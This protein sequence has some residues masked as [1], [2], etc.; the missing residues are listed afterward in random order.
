VKAIIL[1][2]GVGN[3]LKPVTDTMPKCLIEIGGKTILERMLD[4]LIDSGVEDISLVVGYKKRMIVDFAG[5]KYRGRAFDFIDNP[6]YELGSIVSLLVAREKFFGSDALLMDA[7]VIFERAVLEKLIGSKNANCFV[8][9]RDFGLWGLKDTGEEMK[10]AAL[11]KKVVQIARKI[12]REHDEA[13][14]GVG[15]C[16]I[17]AAYYGEF[18]KALENR[19]CLNRNCDYELALD[20]FIT[21]A[22]AGFE[23]ITGMKW[24]EIDFQED[25][26]KAGS[27][28]L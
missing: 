27:L 8:I 21:N 17:S 20:D 12:T 14:E 3:R 6:D 26:G 11:D 23:E 4:S 1:A 5:N 16:K 25:I 24:T 13:G 22:P 9:D 7:D 28:G 15:F 10:V 19:V 2:A 18:L